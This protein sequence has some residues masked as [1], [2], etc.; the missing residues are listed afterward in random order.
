MVACK[1]KNRVVLIPKKLRAALLDYI[2]RA[3]I[4]RGMIF[5][6]RSGRAVNRGNVWAEMKALCAAARVQPSK[7]FPHNLRKLFA[8]AFYSV[9]KDIAKLADVLGYSSINTTRIYIATSGREH[10]QR[11]DRLGLVV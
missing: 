6:T 3:G 11:L 7:V 10:L 2:K 1:N 4:L 8:A 5:V 9:D